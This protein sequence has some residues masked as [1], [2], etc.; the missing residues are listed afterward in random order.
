MVVHRVN[1]PLLWA[2]SGA[3]LM[4]F[5]VFLWIY[6]SVSLFLSIVVYTLYLLLQRYGKFIRRSDAAKASVATALLAGSLT[7]LWYS[8]SATLTIFNK[9]L[10][11]S[12]HG[13]FEYPLLTTSV[14]MVRTEVSEV[15]METFWLMNGIRIELHEH[16]SLQLDKSN[17]PSLIFRRS[18]HTIWTFL[19]RGSL[20]SWQ[21]RE[22][23]YCA[24]LRWISL[25]TRGTLLTNDLFL[26]W[27]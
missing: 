8:I 1:T 26:T 14:H 23:G 10:M 20:W 18:P 16:T 13:G 2:N 15:I 24:I 9:W 25:L 11:T 4:D 7:F 27:W 3:S 17:A 12:W 22:Y 21:L 5:F 19:F 6:F